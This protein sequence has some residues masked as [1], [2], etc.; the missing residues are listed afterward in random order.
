MQTGKTIN[1]YFEVEEVYYGYTASLYNGNTLIYS[2]LI[3]ELDT[4]F[5]YTE[6]T[7][8]TSLIYG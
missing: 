1:A 5:S 4:F 8:G 7:N 3:T 6:A 2:Q